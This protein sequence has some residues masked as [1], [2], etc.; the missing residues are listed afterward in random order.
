M[1]VRQNDGFS[2]TEDVV[3][4][5]GSDSGILTA[6]ECTIPTT[7]LTSAPYSL[8]LGNSVFAK[9]VATNVKGESISS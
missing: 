6:L 7:T 8:S 4:C 5:D 3:S 1:T 2:Y 9:I